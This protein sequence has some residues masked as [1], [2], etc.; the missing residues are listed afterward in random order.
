MLLSETEPYVYSGLLFEVRCIVMKVHSTYIT[1][2][3]FSSEKLPEGE[4][5]LRVNW[6]GTE[7]RYYS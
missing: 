6:R 7:E 1:A 5:T 4:I 3:L 2:S